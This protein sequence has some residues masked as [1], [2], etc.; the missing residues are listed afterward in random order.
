MKSN[1]NQHQHTAHDSES[2]FTLIETACAMVVMMVGALA[3]SSLFVFAAHNNVGGSERALAMAVAQ[4]E[5]E[6]LRS[7][8]FT[9]ATLVAGTT[10]TTP[11]RSGGRE[12]TVVKRVEDL[13]NA[14][15]SPRFLKRITI[16]VTPLSGGANW[17]R[18]PVILVS[19]RSSG[20]IGAFAVSN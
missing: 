17:I 4:K 18:T 5:Q 10:T 8:S 12:Y 15:A 1:R 19:H 7:V 2:G 13:T 3:M 20:A 11:V 6:Q 9:D 14:N 16:T